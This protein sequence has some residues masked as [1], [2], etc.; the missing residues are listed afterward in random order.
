MKLNG[1]VGLVLLAAGEGKRYGSNKLTEMIG[2]R[3]LFRYG[4]EAAAG[5][6]EAFGIE[7]VIVTGYDEIARAAEE[8]G[9]RTVLNT[10]PQLGISRSVQKGLQLLMHCSA[11]IFSVCDQP[12]ITADTFAGLYRAYISS[13]KGL[14]CLSFDDSLGNPCIFSSRY[15]DELMKLEG[16]KGGKKVIRAHMED[17]LTVPAGAGEL[18][19]IDYRTDAFPDS[20]QH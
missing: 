10:E 13:E 2:D 15:F 12:G 7:A 20:E 5:F 14:A 9:F 17:L 6:A 8:K 3:Q 18:K 19:D 4:L 11:V 1:N 16:D